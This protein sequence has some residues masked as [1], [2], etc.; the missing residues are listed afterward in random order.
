MGRPAG[1]GSFYSWSVTGKRL[2]VDLRYLSTSW[3]W[4]QAVAD[5]RGAT[6][7]TTLRMHL[8]CTGRHSEGAR[9]V[10]PSPSTPRAARCAQAGASLQTS[11][12]APEAWHRSGTLSRGGTPRWR[13]REEQRPH[14]LTM[15]CE[16]MPTRLPSFRLLGMA[17]PY[18]MLVGSS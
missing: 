17:S 18:S 13:T 10:T 14:R 2:S 12:A 16:A 8:R 3:L 15:P 11:T 7:S 9:N 1:H 4:W 6:S 5:M